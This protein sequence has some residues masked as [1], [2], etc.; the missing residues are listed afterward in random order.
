MVE[1]FLSITLSASQQ[2]VHPGIMYARFRGWKGEVWEAPSRFYHD[3]SD[4]EVL[5]YFDRR[6]CLVFSN[7]MLMFLLFGFRQVFF[8]GKKYFCSEHHLGK[9][10]YQSISG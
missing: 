6:E 5:V 1:S 3:V 9:P 2:V 8:G 10:Q 7:S 4:E